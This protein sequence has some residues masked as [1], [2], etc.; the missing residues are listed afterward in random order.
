[1][2]IVFSKE[3]AKW[4][5]WA[6]VTLAL[7]VLTAAGLAYG[8]FWYVQQGGKDDVVA[9]RQLKEA[10][11]RLEIARRESNDL[12]ASA[13]VFRDLVNRGI[14]RDENRLELVE[15]LDTLKAR[16]HLLALDYEIAPQRPLPLAGGR[17]FNA[18]DVLGS[19]VKVTLKSLHEG[20]ALAFLDDLA[21]P[22]KG[23]NPVSRCHIQRSAV[24]AVDSVTP[25][26][27]A[28]CTLEWISLKDKRGGR[29][30]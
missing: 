30:S 16:H 22:A 19:R 23:F 1:M 4:L 14:L 9:K 15:R 27:E 5:R 3:G 18:V 20:D 24:T 13:D 10:Q 12:R 26:I 6:W 11:A 28:Q 21:N 25:R 7:A 8:S 29:A 17:S 2:N